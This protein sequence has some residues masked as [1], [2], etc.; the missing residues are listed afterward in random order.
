V[1]PWI[2]AL[3]VEQVAEVLR[4]APHEQPWS[5]EARTR[6]VIRALLCL[7]GWRWFA[8]ERRAFI[9]VAKARQ[10]NG[11]RQPRGWDSIFDPHSWIVIG[12]CPICD[13]PCRSR[14]GHVTYCSPACRD[15]ADRIREREQLGPINL[16]CWECDQLLIE[17]RPDQRYCNRTCRNQATA[18][19]AIEDGRS[20]G[21][22][23]YAHQRAKAEQIAR[24]TE[25]PRIC[26]ECDGPLPVGAH[27]L[28]KFCSPECKRAVDNRNLA[29]KARRL[30]G[31]ANGHDH[32]DD[33]GHAADARSNGA[34]GRERGAQ[35]RAGAGGGEARA[36]RDDA[37]AGVA[38][39][40]ATVG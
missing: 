18:R 9:L 23:N 24:E 4:L 6:H 32:E 27:R 17:P 40:A 26:P 12:C 19:R 3:T 7:G 5:N 29:R 2:E 30:N 14:E 13:R 38:G 8:A 35:D 11:V 34:R 10:K 37:A 20:R 25:Q 16:R 39:S 31:H 33:H 28:R 21:R 36:P 15:R 1:R 22:I